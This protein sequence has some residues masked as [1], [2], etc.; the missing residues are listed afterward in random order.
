MRRYSIG[1]LMLLVAVLAA[2]FALG[3]YL[4]AQ[5]DDIQRMCLAG[6]LPLIDAQLV[7]L[8]LL[9]AR[10]RVALRRRRGS[11]LPAF[12]V[13]ATLGL[14][15]M[16]ALCLAAPGLVVDGIELTWAQI[17]TV[18]DI[19]S[20]SDDQSALVLAGSLC[21]V[22]SGPAVLAALLV[23]GVMARYRLVVVPRRAIAAGDDPTQP[24]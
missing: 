3:R 1:K 6:L 14:G 12:V 13:V 5:E 24:G 19:D 22:I 17:D 18:F 21:L 8:Y 16:L 9:L 15:V 7:G 11:P 2:N 23:G 20:I 4:L 10:H